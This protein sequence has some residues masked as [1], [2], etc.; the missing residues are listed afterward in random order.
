MPCSNQ[1]ANTTR[2]TCTYP[3]CPR[4]GICCDCVAYHRG[5][6]ELPGCLFTA[7]EERT[8]D[9]SVAFFTQSRR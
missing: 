8:W 2:C 5:M 4:H 6:D 7:Q 9:R 3:G 1:P